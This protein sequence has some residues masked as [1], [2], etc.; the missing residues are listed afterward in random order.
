MANYKQ[1]DQ[2]LKDCAPQSLGEVIAE[3][4]VTGAVMGGTSGFVGGGPVGAAVGAGIGAVA[5]VLLPPVMMAMPSAVKAREKNS[6]ACVGR[7]VKKLLG[8]PSP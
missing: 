8:P 5:G 3:T 2:I 4:V 6:A 7:G 1:M